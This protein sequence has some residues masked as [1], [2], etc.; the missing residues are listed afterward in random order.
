MNFAHTNQATSGRNGPVVQRGRPS[1]ALHFFSSVLQCALLHLLDPEPPR[2]GSKGWDRRLCAAR[3][4]GH[5][6]RC[7]RWDGEVAQPAVRAATETSIFARRF[8]LR[9]WTHR[10]ARLWAGSSNMNA[11][12]LCHRGREVRLSEPGYAGHL[13]TSASRCPT[14]ACHLLEPDR[15]SADAPPDS[16]DWRALCSL[17]D[18]PPVFFEHADPGAGHL[19]ILVAPPK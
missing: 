14:Q 17:V 13:R 4:S 9:N 12:W 15:A 10:Q 19:W 2:I 11:L 1:E 3:A 5:A 8:A 6:R 16:W 18:E 7:C